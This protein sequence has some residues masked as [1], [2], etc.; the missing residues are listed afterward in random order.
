METLPGVAKVRRTPPHWLL[1][2][3]FIVV[4]VAL[5]FGVAQFGEDRNNRHLATRA[6]AS[7][8]AELEHNLAI[9]E[10]MVPIHRRWVE[11]LAKA[12][13]SKSSQSALDVYFATRPDLPADSKS[14]FP[15]LRRSAW[16][17]AMSGGALRLIDY[18]VATALSEIYR[19]QE[20]ATGNVERLAN[21]ALSSTAI[22]EPAS[23]V[24]AVRLLWLTLA[25]IQ[26]A[27]A[28][29][30]DLYRQHLPTIRGAANAAR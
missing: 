27:E 21:G 26:S 24:S 12:D 29:L 8:Q 16:D 4:S 11:D 19:L 17:A 22:F 1:E 20:I 2:G 5:G 14:P 13:T 23:R 28:A 9:L 18:D 15:F 7:L 3:L 30:L 25:D 6:L 10:P